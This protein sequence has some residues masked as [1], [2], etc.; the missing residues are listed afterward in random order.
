MQH[1]WSRPE[2][3]WI[4]ARVAR[5]AGLKPQD[6][7]S[8]TESIILRQ[9]RAERLSLTAYLRLLER[10]A[11]VLEALC[12][13]LT[14]G[15]TYF[16]RDSGQF[17]LIRKRILP[18]IIARKADAE[19]IRMWSAGCAT[20]EEAYSLA[21]VAHELG[22]AHRAHVVATDLARDRLERARAGRYGSWS[23]RGMPPEMM[24][25]YFRHVGRQHEVDPTVREL[26][27]FQYL[28]LAEDVYP[29]I[30]T[31]VWG[32]DLI[33]CRNVLIYLDVAAVTLVAR[34]LVA[35]LAEDG[36]LLLGATDP[37][38][39]QAA[40]CD[41]V[42]TDAG[43]AYRPAREDHTAGMEREAAAPPTRGAPELSTARTATV[44]SAPTRSR[45]ERR[46]RAVRRPVAPAAERTVPGIRS[47]SDT[48]ADEVRALA[49]QA[50]LLSESGQLTAAVR[51]ARQALYLEPRFIVAHLALG[52]ALARLH[53]RSG[54]RRSFANAE[55][56][57]AGKTA[58]EQVHAAGGESA[59]RLLEI[60]R[61]HLRLTPESAS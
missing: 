43:L 15:E 4:A 59:G 27:D 5:V 28:N 36:W 25:P 49:N 10:D 42:V 11:R 32:M 2:Y 9:A 45:I 58:D 34:R 60:A 22:V 6:P 51:A 40:V 44:T 23:F 26:V 13:E 52:S 57:L 61:M 3:E 8:R 1:G 46:P 12:A 17:A 48:A 54:A 14:V 50:V 35:A 31:N 30:S 53:D 55:R 37:A 56:L 20:G 21:I 38:I 19:P 41:V 7:S 18:S 39:G 24:R 29:S 33:L 16:F 47:G